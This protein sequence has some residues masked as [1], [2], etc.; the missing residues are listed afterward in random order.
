MFQDQVLA[1]ETGQQRKAG[2]RQ[3]ARRER[4]VR[5]GHGTP[6]PAH[7]ADVLFLVHA[8]D[9]AAGA[10]EQQGLEEGVRHDVEHR[11]RVRPHPEAEKHVAELAH[12]GV[13]QHFLDVGL[14]QRDRGREQRGRRADDGHHAQRGRRQGVQKVQAGDQI[15]AGGDHRRGM[16]QRADRRGASHGVGQPDVERNLRR[17]AGRGDE[18]EQTDERHRAGRQQGGVR[19]D[20]AERQRPYVVRGQTPE[21]DEQPEQESG[22]ADAVDDERLLAGVG[23]LR[24]GVPEPDQQVGAQADAFPADEQQQQV[25]AQH[26]Q[27]HR[28]GEQVKVRE[29]ARRVR[30]L[31]H[32]ADR[33]H[34]DEKPDAG[35]D[36]D[37]RRGQRVHAQRDVDGQR[38]GLQ[39]GIDAVH[40][41]AAVRQLHQRGE[42]QTEGSQ[43][44][45]GRH[46]VDRP[47]S[48]T[49]GEEQV[50]R[51]SQQ[52]QQHDVAE[53]ADRLHGQFGRVF[54]C[55]G[56]SG[57]DAA[58]VSVAENRICAAYVCRRGALPDEDDT[59]LTSA[60]GRVRPRARSAC[61]GTRAE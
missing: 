46:P 58:R 20:R 32:V 57:R 49:R 7:A 25:V 54:H 9:D 24:V 13:G 14:H 11:G 41:R 28:R 60:S 56:S 59:R 17:L 36:D 19:F 22:V 2:D 21:Q 45:A 4:A 38:T 15:D 1:E 48:A 37:H 42:R 31:G 8:V 39:P 29:I 12:R 5:D 33:I 35:D 34:V 18:E 23:L 52:G 43:D 47:P 26:Q 55:S 3:T 6:Q 10:Q 50:E 51:D 44:D 16:D 53:V 30:V 61:R 40:Q 27:Q